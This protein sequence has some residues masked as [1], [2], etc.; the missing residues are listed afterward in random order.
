MAARCVAFWT[1]TLTAAVLW[2]ESDV[3]FTDGWRFAK[4][5]SDRADWSAEAFDDSTWQQVRVPHDW[6]IAGPFTTNEASGVTGG[7]SRWTRRT[8]RDAYSS[9]SMA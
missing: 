4:D 1:A 8:W 2:S 3:A 9:T 6:A 5:A 7:G